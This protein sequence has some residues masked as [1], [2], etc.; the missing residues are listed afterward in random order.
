MNVTKIFRQ[1]YKKYG[2]QHWW[3]TCHSRES[4]SPNAIGDGN[5]AKTYH[6]PFFEICVG[7]ILTQNTTWTNVEKAI[8]CLLAANLMS[9]KAIAA[10][11]T[12]KLQKCI[13]SSGY[14]KQKAKKLKIF[15]QWLIKN[16]NGNLRLFFKKPLAPA[17]KELLSLWG[18]GPET[19][20]SIL[21]YAGK[22][23]IFVID[24]YTKRLCRRYGVEF[25]IYDEYQKFF[26]THLRAGL[27]GWTKTKL[28]N[29][30]H[31]LIV[32]WGKES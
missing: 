9:P 4:L 12:R 15:S 22:K 11:P 19:A 1:L 32:K 5:S 24:A 23:P 14:Y 6:N 27:R 30:Y 20:D 18:I 2:S 29:E 16:Y 28:Y 26:E 13:H 7:A 21:L 17:R 8:K 10:C 31:A 25:K 3:P